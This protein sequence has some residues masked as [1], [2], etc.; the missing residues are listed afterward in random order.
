MKCKELKG[1][2]SVGH[3]DFYNLDLFAFKY[4]AHIFGSNF[5]WGKT[6]TLDIQKY[7]K[8]IRSFKKIINIWEDAGKP[9]I[10]NMTSGKIPVKIYCKCLFHYNTNTWT[11][12][13]KIRHNPKDRYELKLD[14]TDEIFIHEDSSIYG[15]VKKMKEL[16]LGICNNCIINKEDC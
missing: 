14:E 6:Y 16:I 3:D 9:R 13:L 8:V 10:I 5:I 15:N 12:Y 1:I 11:G 7:K 4:K 2:I